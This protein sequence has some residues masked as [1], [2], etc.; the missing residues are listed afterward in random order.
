MN[1]KKKNWVVVHRHYLKIVCVCRS[2]Y[3]LFCMYMKFTATLGKFGL[4]IDGI[5][6]K[7]NKFC[8]ETTKKTEK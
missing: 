8:A 7:T 2:T 5:H 4:L 1:S 3:F 6:A